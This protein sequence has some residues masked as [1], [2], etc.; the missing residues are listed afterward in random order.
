MELQSSDKAPE[1]SQ[2]TTSP[3]VTG[4][5]VL[6]IRY[7]GGVM[8]MADTLGSY[9]TL[10]RFKKLE[11]IKQVN[12][13]T[14]IGAGG[15][16]SDWQQLQDWL[17]E[18][19]ITDF[20]YDDGFQQTP[21]DVHNLLSRILYNRRCKADPLWNNLLVAG[22]KPAG[23]DEK[24]G[25]I[26]LGAVDLYGSTY[27]DDIL[28]TGYGKYI[29]IPLLRKGWKPNL[30]EN[31]A[32]KLLE[33][34]MRVLFYRDCKTI[35]RFNLAKVTKDG[36][37]TAA[38]YLLPTASTRTGTILYSSTLKSPNKGRQC[39]CKMSNLRMKMN[40]LNVR[41][42]KV[43]HHQCE[44]RKSAASPRDGGS[45]S[46]VEI[47]KLCF[48]LSPHRAFSRLE[49]STQQP[50]IN[51]RKIRRHQTQTAWS[52]SVQCNSRSAESMLQ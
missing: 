33:D 45:R 52:I 5:S 21:R 17:K 36:C 49:K 3:V 35:N 18:E 2:R 1:G 12:D 10:S 31:E 8:M 47:L 13:N 32:K 27:E 4:S 48:T 15:D 14:I 50:S 38:P 34:S 24:E 42:G 20:C 11:R 22:Y 43:Q 39:Y 19:M 26:F 9:G 37:T 30:S 6:A 25:S 16:Y 29:A 23:E 41:R 51:I 7:A 44:K 28:A 46:S 40:I